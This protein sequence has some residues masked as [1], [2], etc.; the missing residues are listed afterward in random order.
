[1]KGDNSLVY[2]QT[3]NQDF[4]RAV[5]RG[6]FRKVLSLLTGANN[7]LLRYDEVRE[8]IPIRGQHYLGVKQ[9]PIEKI[10]GSMGRYHDF[11]RAFLPTQVR[12][13]N[14]WVSIDKAHYAQVELPPV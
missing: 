14:R 10:V 7:E 9:V 8:Q 1:M 12:T 5:M 2:Q 3:A 13:K 6:F 4:E 11:D